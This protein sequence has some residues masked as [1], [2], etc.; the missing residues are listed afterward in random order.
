MARLL[1]V[2]SLICLALAVA[3]LFLQLCAPSTCFWSTAPRRA[4]VLRFDDRNLYVSWRP[5]AAYRPAWAGQVNRFGVRFTRWSDGSGEVGV[6]IAFLAAVLVVPAVAA[7]LVAR[8]LRRRAYARTH[9]LCPKCGYD[10]RATPQ[11]CPE[12][13][14]CE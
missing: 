9:K 13:S 1:A 4:V 11:R 3:C 6:P 5:A 2:L 14:Y 7:Y 12:C 8:K 10:L